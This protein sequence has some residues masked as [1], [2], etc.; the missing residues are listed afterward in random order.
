MK[1]HLFIALLIFLLSAFCYAQEDLP[2]SQT[3]EEET[4]DT[5]QT[6]EVILPHIYTYIDGPIVEQRKVITSQEIQD[7][8]A[9]SLTDILSQNG[10]QILSYGAYGLETKPSIRGFTDETVRVVI[11]GVCVNNAQYGTFDFTSINLSSIEKIEIVKGGFTE[12]VNDEGAVGGVIYITTKKQSLTTQIFSD[13]YLKTYFNPQY[14]VDTLGESFSLMF[15]LFDSSYLKFTFSGTYATN[16]FYYKDYRKLI[17]TRDDSQVWDTTASTSYTQ[18]FGS[19]NSFTISDSIYAANKY[20]PGTE[21][22]TISGLQKDY[23]NTL[24]TDITFPSLWN[25]VKL[26]SS[27]A[28]LK[29]IRFYSPDGTFT[30]S[31][32]S[33]HYLDTFK[34]SLQGTFFDSTFFNQSLGT[35]LEYVNLNS[36]D[37]GEHTQFS[38]D[39]ASTTKFFL[40][41]GYDISI[42]LSAKFCGT[43]FAFVPKAGI[44][45]K[46]NASKLSFDFYRM[47]QFPN[48]DDLYWSGSNYHGNPDLKPEDGWGGD[49]TYNSTN[50]ILPFSVDLFVNYYFNKIQW[51]VIDSVWQS[52]NIASAFYAGIDFDAQQNFLNKSLTIKFDFEYLYNCLLD[53]TN[54]DT[55]G[56]R[57]MMTPDI[58]SSLQCSY[59]IAS[60]NIDLNLTYVGKRYKTNLNTAYLDPYLLV[61]TAVTWNATTH[62]APYFRIDNLLNWYYYAYDSYPMPGISLTAGA[63]LKW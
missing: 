31:S 3:Q 42:P 1:R 63:R 22:T 13:T 11:D 32:D 54:S 47:V 21:T 36:T 28:Y 27:F 33:S 58:T 26:Q 23:D 2:S 46:F 39:F 56:K 10:I 41:G 4:T 49:I 60:F 61:N 24:L 50:K 20:C 59:N 30:S 25:A 48:M 35:S 44:S 29:N 12:S 37:D 57:I 34:Y 5:T 43:N 16:C 51:T 38:A 45:K 40:N 17:Q 6:D 14:P 15:P 53:S 55:Y 52:A 19:G 9:Q 18:Y 7:S 62:I 8:H